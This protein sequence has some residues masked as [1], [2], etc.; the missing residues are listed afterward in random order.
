MARHNELG[1]WGEQ[2]A[3]EYLISQGYTVID[4][5]L[6][7]GHKEIDI[8]ATKDKWMVF[9]E[10]KTRSKE[11]EDALDAVDSR[12]MLRMVRAADAFMQRYS[13]PYEYRFDII[14]VIGNPLSGHTLHHFPDAFMPPLMTY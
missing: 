10:V 6:H 11:L 1:E 5:N 14:A 3:R 9:V 13:V 2:I 8:I 12:K 4:R 7:V